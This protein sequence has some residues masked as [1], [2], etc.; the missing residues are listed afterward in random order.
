MNG[1]LK[2]ATERKL[3]HISDACIFLFYINTYYIRSSKQFLESRDMLNPSRN[4]VGDVWVVH[5]NLLTDVVG[6]I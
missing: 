1:C 6:K 2:S 3:T 5:D 4:G